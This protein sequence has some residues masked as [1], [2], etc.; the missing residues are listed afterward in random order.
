[1]ESAKFEL[2]VNI[3]CALSVT[4]KPS[5]AKHI[6]FSSCYFLSCIVFPGSLLF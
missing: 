2:H 4:H 3:V 6:I 1:M 5:S